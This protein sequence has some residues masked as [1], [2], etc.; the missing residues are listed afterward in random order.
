MKQ[1]GMKKLVIVINGSGGVGKD[2]L[3]DSLRTI[4]RVTNISAITP[5]KNIAKMC[6]WNGEKDEKSRRFLANLK[7]VFAEYNDLPNNYLVEEYRKF[8]SNDMEILCVHIREK[9][10]IEKFLKSIALPSITLLIKRNI[11]LPKGKI[12]NDADDRVEEYCYDYVF[13]NSDPVEVS[14]EKFRALIRGVF[15]SLPDFGGEK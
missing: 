8:V 11:K 15:Q 5:I 1:R 2:T 14:T 9:D 4:Y 6:G 7:R 10:Q 12:G 3:C 13:D